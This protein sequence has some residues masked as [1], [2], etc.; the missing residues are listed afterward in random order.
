MSPR[1]PSCLPKE[2]PAQPGETC[3]FLDD[4]KY[5]HMDDT[6][7]E[8]THIDQAMQQITRELQK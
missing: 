8:K 3:Y 4:F 1:D 7:P 6:L 5:S 2:Y